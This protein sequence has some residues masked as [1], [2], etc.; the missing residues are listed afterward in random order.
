M[1]QYISSNISNIII[2]NIEQKSL[3]NEIFINNIDLS[4]YNVYSNVIYSNYD[5]ETNFDINNS[6][7]EIIHNN[8][9][10]NI[11]KLYTYN[12]NIN[13]SNLL[14]SYTFNSNLY[15]NVFE[16]ENYRKINNISKY[17][18]LSS[19]YNDNN[20]E[21]NYD[22]CNIIFKY[23]DLIN[24]NNQTTYN[25]NFL[26][27]TICDILIVAGGGGGGMDMG[28]GGGGGGIIYLQ[29]TLVTKGKKVIK[30]G[31]GGTGAPA[32]G[33]NGQ[34]GGHHY[35]IN[36]TSGSDSQF[37]THIAVGGGYGG[38][39]PHNHTLQGK[40]GNGGSGGGSSGYNANNDI[41]DAGTGIDGQGYRGAYGKTSHYSG[42]GGGAGEI[43]GGGSDDASER[44]RGGDGLAFD[45]LGTL[46]YWGGGGGGSGYSTTGGDGGKGGGGGGAIGITYGGEGGLN[47]GEPGGAGGTNSWA[48]RPGGNAGKHTGGGGGGGSHYN[49]NNKGGDGGSG[50]VI[51]KYSHNTS[52]YLLATDNS[53]TTSYTTTDNLYY[54]TLNIF[55]QYEINN[56]YFNN[57]LTDNF[58]ISFWINITGNNDCDIIYDSYNYFKFQYNYNNHLFYIINDTNTLKYKILS[59]DNFIFICIIFTKN[60]NDYYITLYQNDKIVNRYDDFIE[61]ITFND[62]INNKF[63]I[64]NATGNFQINNFKIYNT[65]LTDNSINLLYQN[66]KI[67]NYD[68]TKTNNLIASEF[69]KLETY[70][71]FNNNLINL[72]NNEILDI[73]NSNYKLNSDYIVIYNNKFIEIPN[74]HCKNI[75]NTIDDSTLSI[76]FYITK[77]LEYNTQFLMGI[78]YTNNIFILSIAQNGSSN[79]ISWTKKNYGIGFKIKCNYDDS[80]YNNW[81]TITLISKYNNNT[82]Q[83]YP[84]IYIN[85]INQRIIFEY[86][87]RYLDDT[88]LTNNLNNLYINGIVEENNTLSN[89]NGE[90]MFK[91]LRIYSRELNINE[92]RLI[93][94]YTNIT[95]N[96]GIYNIKDI[97][98]T[99]KER[100]YPPTRNLTSASHTIS[101]Q[102]YGNGL[103]ETSHSAVY[104]SYAGY[105]A[106]NTGITAGYHSPSHYT[107]SSG[108]FNDSYF[109][110]D[111]GNLTSFDYTGDWVKIKLPVYINLTKY[112]LK[113]RG[114]VPNRSPKDYRIYGSNDNTNW[115]ILVDKAGDNAIIPTYYSSG[116]F[117]ESVSMIGEYQYFLIIVNKLLGNDTYLNLD[118]WYIYGVEKIDIVNGLI[119]H[120]KFDG[121]LVDKTTDNADLSVVNSLN[122]YLF[123]DDYINVTG[124]TRLQIPKT[125]LTE[126]QTELTIGF[127]CAKISGTSST[128]NH[129]IRYRPLNLMVRYNYNS[130]GRINLLLE[131]KDAYYTIDLTQDTFTNLLFTV[132]G[133]TYKI[134][135][136]GV[137]VTWTSITGDST[138]DSNGFTHGT[139]TDKFE[140]F[141][142]PDNSTDFRGKIKNF[143]IYDRALSAAEVEKLYLE[144]SEKKAIENNIIQDSTDEYITFKYSSN[145]ELRFVFREDESPNSWQE[146]YDEA[147]ANGGRMPTKTELL[148]YLSSLGYTLQND[149]TKSPLYNEDIWTPVIAEY[150]NGRDWI[151]LG[152][153][154]SH[155][156]GKSHTEHHGYPSWGDTADTRSYKRIYVEVYEDTK[157]K[158]N[159]NY[160]IFFKENVECDVLIVG[161]GGSGYVN[162]NFND[163][164]GGGGGGGGGGLVY[165]SSHIFNGYYNLTVGCGGD[166]NSD[167][168]AS[169]LTDGNDIYYAF[170]GNSGTISDGG[171]S[172]NSY[173]TN[174][175]NVTINTTN[176]NGGTS[177]ISTS[178]TISGGGAG[179]AENGNNNGTG[180]DGIE[181]NINGNNIYYSSGGGGGGNTDSI[182]NGGNGGAETGVNALENTG[183]GGGGGNLTNRSGLGGSGVI[184]FKYSQLNNSKI[185]YWEREPILSRIFT[186]NSIILHYNFSSSINDISGYNNNLIV[187]SSSNTP[188]YSFNNY[189]TDN[190]TIYITNEEFEIPLSTFDILNIQKSF[191]ISF[192][193][194]NIIN[195]KNTL[196][197]T[198]IIEIFFEN[199]NTFNIKSNYNNEIIVYDIDYINNNKFNHFVCVFTYNN[200]I[201]NYIIE[202]EVVLYSN[203]KYIN[204]QNIIFNINNDPDNIINLNK[205][206]ERLNGYLDDFR[207]YNY[208]LSYTEVYNLYLSY[209]IE[210]KEDD[211]YKY[212]I[213]KCIDKNI[214]KYNINFK[215]N[216][217]CDI[218]IVGGGGSSG[219]GGSGSHEPGGGGGGGVIYM[220]N[221]E[222]NKGIYNI[223]V[224]NGGYQLN[225]YD[226]CIK[227]DNIILEIDNIK[228]T[229]YGGGLG[230][231]TQSGYYSSHSSGH[232]PGYDG[233]SGGGASHISYY[234]K[235][236]QGKTVWNGTEYI[237]GGY[238][239]TMGDPYGGSSNDGSGGGG[240]GGINIKDNGGIGA[241][242]NI[243][244]ETK[245]YGGGGGGCG[246]SS[247]GGGLGGLGGGGN[248]RK[249]SHGDGFEGLPYTGGGGGASYGNGSVNKSGGS[250]IVIIKCHKVKKIYS[251]IYSITNKIN[252]INNYNDY[253]TNLVHQYNLENDLNDNITNTSNL[254]YNEV[255]Y[256]EQSRISKNRFIINNLNTY[257][258]LNT[259]FVD[260]YSAFDSEYSNYFNLCEG[261]VLEQGTYK[262]NYYT[263]YLPT[264]GS[265]QGTLYKCNFV[266]NRWFKNFKNEPIVY[267]IGA[268]GNWHNQ[269]RQEVHVPNIDEYR[270]TLT[271]KTV[272]I[273]HTTGTSGWIKKYGE[274]NNTDNVNI[275]NQYFKSQY[276]NYGFPGKDS[277][278][279]YR[280]WQGGSWHKI[281]INKEYTTNIPDKYKYKSNI[282]GIILNNDNYLEL[283]STFNPYTIWNGNG[284]TFSLWYNFT[285]ASRSARFIDFQ[286]NLNSSTGIRIFRNNTSN[287]IINITVNSVDSGSINVDNYFDGKWHNLVFSISKDNIWKL[288]IDNILKY[289]QTKT[290]ISSTINWNYRYINKSVYIADGSFTGAISDF[291]IYNSDLDDNSIASIYNYKKTLLYNLYPEIDTTNLFA[292]YIFNNNI[293]DSGKNNINLIENTSGDIIY[294]SNDIYLNNKYLYSE[295]IELSNS[296]FSISVWFKNYNNTNNIILFRQGNTNTTNTNLYI[297]YNNSKYYIDF[298][299]NRLETIAISNNSDWSHLVFIVKEN[300]NRE[301]WINGKLTA[302]DYNT[303]FFNTTYNLFKIGESIN[304]YLKELYIY[305]KVLTSNEIID[306]YNTNY[307]SLYDMYSDKKY[308]IMTFKY[309]PNND[310][311]SGQTEY[312]I[313]FP[314]NTECDILIV[315]GGGA[316]GHQNAGG[317][318]AGGVIFIAKHI[319]PSGSYIVNVGDG[320]TR[321]PRNPHPNSQRTSVYPAGKRGNNSTLTSI[322][323]SSMEW[324]AI[325]GG[326]GGGDDYYGVPGGS[327]GG[328][329]DDS[330][331]GGPGISVQASH[332]TLYN[333]IG[334]HYGNDGGDGRTG[335]NGYAGAGGGGAGE[336]GFNN[337]NGRHGGIGKYFG[338][339]FGTNV[340]DKGWFAG[341]GGGSV[342]TTDS[343]GIHGIGGM[344]GGGNGAA[345]NGVGYGGLSNTGGGGGGSS[346]LSDGGKGGSGIII[347]RYKNENNIILNNFWNNNNKLSN[348]NLILN[349]KINDEIKL[350]FNEYKFSIFDIIDINIYFNIENIIKSIDNTYPPISYKT[351]PFYNKSA[352][353]HHV[354]NSNYGNGTY[355]ISYSSKSNVY[356]NNLPNQVFS[357]Y[358]GGGIW[359]SLN[360][361]DKTG[362]YIGTTSDITYSRYTGDWIK[363][364]LP[365]Y[366]IASKISFKLFDNNLAFS[367]N[368]PKNY[369]FYG[370]NDEI[371]WVEILS[372]NNVI[373]TNNVYEKEINNNRMF[374]IYILIVNKIGLSHF[375]AFT[376]FKINAIELNNT[377]LEDYNYYLHK[378]VNNLEISQSI[379][380]LEIPEPTICDILLLGGGGAGG[381][382]NGGGGGAGGL[383]YVENETL[384]GLYKITVGKGGSGVSSETKGESGNDSI[385]SQNNINLYVATGG[386]GGGTGNGTSAAGTNGG[387]GGGRAGE[388]NNSSVTGGITTQIVYNLDNVYTFGTNGG[389]APSGYGGSGGGG[390]KEN[391][392]DHSSKNNRYAGR[393]GDGISGIYTENLSVNFKNKFKIT[394]KNIGQHIIDNNNNYN[395]Y[396]GGGGG[397]GNENNY[398]SLYYDQNRGGIGGGGVGG[399]YR[400]YG[401]SSSTQ[402]DAMQNTGSGGGGSFYNNSTATKAGD[403]GSGVVLIKKN[404]LG[405]IWNVIL[406]D[407]IELNNI[408]IDPTEL[409]FNFES[410]IYTYKNFKLNTFIEEK[411]YPS[412]LIRE[413]IRNNNFVIN[414]KFYGNGNYEISY[415]GEN[416]SIINIFKYN[417][418]NIFQEA[419][420]NDN[421]SDIEE[422][423]YIGNDSLFENTTYKGEYV[424]I[425]L[426]YKILL[427]RI[428]LIGKINK[429]NFPS[430]FK[431]YG[432][433]NNENWNEIIIEENYKLNLNENYSNYEGYSYKL[434][435][436]LVFDNYAI[437]VNKLVNGTNLILLAWHLY[438][439]EIFRKLQDRPTNMPINENVKLSQ[440]FQVYNLDN[441]FLNLSNANITITNYYN[442]GEYIDNDN[443]PNL[444]N[445]LGNNSTLT[446]GNFKGTSVDTYELPFI[447]SLYAKY[448]L[449]DESL[450]Q[451]S[452]G[453][454]I[455]WKDSSGNSR[456]IVS[457]RGSPQLTTFTK[458]SKGL[459]GSGDIKVVSGNE[460][461]GYILPFRLPKNYTFCYVARY[462]EVNSTYNKRIFDSRDGEGRNTLWGFHNNKVGLSHNNRNGWIT[463][464]HKKQSEN[465]Y[466]LIGIETKKSARFNGI[467]YTDYYTH[468]D[469]MVLPRQNDSDYDNPWPTINY[470]YYTGQIK[471][472]EVSRW[473][474]AEMIFYDEELEEIDMIKI[475]NYFAKKFGHI[476][477]KNTIKNVELYKSLND[478]TY[479]ND[480]LF[481]YDGN[482]Y[483]YNNTKL[484]GPIPNRFD[485]LVYNNNVYSILL[486]TNNV[487]GGWWGR[488]VAKS[489]YSNRNSDR[490]IYPDININNIINYSS[491]I[492]KYKYVNMLVL[493]GGGGGGG[494]S[495]GGGGGAGGQAYIVNSDNINNVSIDLKIGFRGKGGDYWSWN[496]GSSGGDT[497]IIITDNTNT[498]STTTLIGY[499]GYEGRTGGRSTVSGG[500]YNISN[501][502]FVGTGEQGGANG[503]I[504]K[505][506]GCGGACGGA[507]STATNKNIGD[508]NDKLWSIINEYI[509]VNNITGYSR[510]ESYNSGWWWLANRVGAGGQGARGGYSG[511]PWARGG[512]PGGGGLVAIILD[513]N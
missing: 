275:Y 493:G 65:K 367:N 197:H 477:F 208:D 350:N 100:V 348:S 49:S 34:P 432:S 229:A 427:T 206:G 370:T 170:G 190:S 131:G 467:D 270:F 404:Y 138:M 438:G 319:L 182:V 482:R 394:D 39:G 428:S 384:Q 325:G 459:Y 209:N 462:S 436:Y 444:L 137:E 173:V 6:N 177:V 503:G 409:I 439:K 407:N 446:F 302:Y 93:N 460:S 235:S 309:N 461:S 403:G 176:N 498:T 306:L 349:T 42:G 159:S 299:N 109:N 469:G 126:G 237:S 353:I 31:N 214:A 245:Y 194:K 445:D 279:G 183:G 341:G 391:G 82:K 289:N 303:D 398:V 11:Y 195:S 96:H 505:S 442:G 474:V 165:I 58:T 372:D 256:Y 207:I 94:K 67:N 148:N 40:A 284:I 193:Y 485:M 492:Y 124:D 426:P 142:N 478:I 191:T 114:G 440:L 455:K 334:T 430:D 369:K 294:N 262:V 174:L 368:F 33:T 499:G 135:V 396:F 387:C 267:G 320:A 271:E 12:D 231:G 210:L 324:I 411:L 316:G 258:N 265:D 260:F 187:K 290:G 254:L 377:D 473:Q 162:E 151:Q 464:Q 339:I 513:F 102:L 54:D 383:V 53:L 490:Y 410:E 19:I 52:N 199:Q 308:N 43:G 247:V 117:Q 36:A 44:Q 15:N 110:N 218:L 68:I 17:N 378:P 175:T 180:G 179:S 97:I 133:E 143:R 366:I 336:K 422:H 169:L 46:Y 153:T 99:T 163:E 61:L 484:Y 28:G 248:A 355:F 380:Y 27:D 346:A 488:G 227:K 329:A 356:I 233:G 239:S 79:I 476:S 155:W 277:Y 401:N 212:Y 345:R 232:V 496:G 417:R 351:T 311:G 132:N 89:Y 497:E 144:G 118:E 125:I 230:G 364:V 73:D 222:F 486:Y 236:L 111:N 14:I 421:Y 441:N 147:I 141:S 45:I 470:G 18:D 292:H 130:D 107:S 156:I 84:S 343:G 429:N 435:N 326:N 314:Q 291:R 8:I 5:I 434:N 80:I 507:I 243:F 186:N 283:P 249:K 172:G 273:L 375:L 269:W 10:N 196:L 276:N 344:G 508:D 202:Y 201:N 56:F 424:K 16:I 242:I 224:G 158:K 416:S 69:Y 431:L 70:Y 419:I 338:D 219:K 327:G 41:N 106:F 72:I 91:N 363:I 300:N 420:W 413:N 395:V 494:T 205:S 216:T 278:W 491:Q 286:E 13:Y 223:S 92:I 361:D 335:G 103:Y 86:E 240:A 166:Y 506:N 26:Q 251:E 81:N 293:N 466:W 66:N 64:G 78:N 471:T 489:G 296:E 198:S 475:E 185:K 23:D 75:L 253:T 305:K 457:Y 500:S 285:S 408:Y 123:V 152:V 259:T 1:A 390:L 244:G 437:V 145:T 87:F 37:D 21:I 255:Y 322:D 77:I 85:G 57:L 295:V 119:A 512:D 7:Y 352:V 501:N 161:G 250:G 241:K 360:Y 510:L 450:L 332:G 3:N 238:S 136:N 154:S 225:G 149:D 252:I 449:D 288:Y 140:F 358:L 55:K 213:F 113:Q 502:L 342:K 425:K 388:Y 217:V 452:S 22:N 331:N 246:G 76:D 62:T 29:N 347:I 30:V 264:N 373:M 59:N 164:P 298:Y 472:T 184:I 9:D 321:G 385:I 389:N 487:G 47:E 333:N 74:A 451:I 83:F 313:N 38:S 266:N 116:L 95:N 134:Y 188:K 386:G 178:G 167:G 146:A 280:E 371:E 448:Y 168:S 257:N 4:F 101:Q 465:D 318:G 263:G 171:N 48:N 433:N 381:Y 181:I 105:S 2:K 122:G 157:N 88:I 463:M 200:T 272:L 414:N 307:I 108:V 115:T 35:T 400:H 453:K 90:K 24:N 382:D 234:G 189:V 192:W 312:T 328:G 160:T 330:N 480:I 379:Y 504:G 51:I 120:Y 139:S 310:N 418:E 402:H 221:K 287:T 301:I 362:K 458:G 204:K 374:K 121:D 226:S 509:S 71:N 50:I 32:A 495:A 468:R 365:H 282:N 261:L 150:S 281:K 481:T 357:N 447:D 397:G 315:A 63:Y 376:D 454:L 25:I 98:T 274:W 127:W 323:D 406:N 456:D 412:Y 423:Q 129:I 268:Q 443:V 128:G 104:S 60:N 297:G 392:F 354:T 405:S 211:Y 393:G 511:D 359:K 337:N 415:T 483:F 317:G 304:G 220:T 215:N 20:I 340:G 228:L 399:G 479:K 112:G 203:N